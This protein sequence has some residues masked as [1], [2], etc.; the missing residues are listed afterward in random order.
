MVCVNTRKGT[1]MK[2]GLRLVLLSWLVLLICSGCS[3]VPVR[4]GELSV[5]E[6]RLLSMK[7]PSTVQQ[8]LPYDILIDFE[9]AGKPQIRK[10][11]FR[12]LTE[13]VRVPSPSLY[14]Y[15]YEAETNGAIGSICSR[16]VAEGPYAQASPLFCSMVE[17]V[18]YDSESKQGRLTVKIQSG[19]V[20]RYY[21]KLECHLE[22]ARGE[23]VD[24]SNK[25]SERL[26]V[27][28]SD[29]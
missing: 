22:Y 19:N 25:V 29:Q 13:K 23:A 18:Q 4:S 8:D 6:V 14:C 17:N 21:N 5:G 7:V 10:A 20:E 15:T 9:S 24:I 27:E 16:W 26:R 12:W 1:Y 11:C 28:R 2:S 3:L